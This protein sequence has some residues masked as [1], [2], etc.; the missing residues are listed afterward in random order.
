MTYN[1][2]FRKVFIIIFNVTGQA[3]EY[4]AAWNV[5]HFKSVFLCLKGSQNEGYCRRI[6]DLIAVVIKSF[7]LAS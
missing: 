7:R 3:T 6:V 2:L 1:K 5:N 4:L